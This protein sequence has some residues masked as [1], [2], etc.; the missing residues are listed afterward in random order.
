MSIFI[1][2]VLVVAPHLAT[3]VV[4]DRFHVT[5]AAPDLRLAPSQYC[6]IHVST[7]FKTNIYSSSGQNPYRVD[8]CQIAVNR[9]IVPE[10]DHVPVT[11]RTIVHV[12]FLVPGAG[13]KLII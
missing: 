7:Y 9:V 13:E 4:R 3:H 8:P 11:D 6:M 5:L 12:R 2:T 1:G 10:I